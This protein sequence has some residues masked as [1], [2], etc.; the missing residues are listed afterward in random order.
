MILVT[1]ASGHVGTLVVR[2]L[3]RADQLVRAFVHSTH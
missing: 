2:A 1:S 3:V